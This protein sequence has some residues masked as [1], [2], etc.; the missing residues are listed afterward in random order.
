MPPVS[1]TLQCQVIKM[2][3]FV[4]LVV[5]CCR[6]KIA[7]V[8][9]LGSFLVRGGGRSFVLAVFLQ[10]SREAGNLLIESPGPL[11][12][13]RPVAAANALSSLVCIKT[14]AV[15]LYHGYTT[16]SWS[17]HNCIR[18]FSNLLEGVKCKILKYN[19]YYN[20]SSALRY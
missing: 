15:P 17:T 18:K 8:F 4:L 16:N 5:V 1:Y 2:A 13:S 14:S 7:S 12:Y 3:L 6:E 20:E 9:Q 11:I 19:Y 10:R